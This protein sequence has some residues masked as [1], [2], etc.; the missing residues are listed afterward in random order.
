MA[1]TL[2]RFEAKSRAAWRAWLKANHRTAPGVWLVTH[3]KG[4]GGPHLPWSEVVDEALCFG[5]IDSLP[6][7]LDATRSMIRVTPRKPTSGWSKINRDKVERLI[8][9]DLMTAS[10]LA[11]V[12]L[13]KQ[14]G[15]WKKLEA[16]DSLALPDDLRA[17]LEALPPALKNFEAFPPSARRAILEWIHAAKRPETRLARVA[18]TATQAALNERANQWRPKG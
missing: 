5:W 4:S 8:A 18:Q 2:P 12:A 15:A 9:Q 14:N 13:A 3:K 6:R 11:A 7:K 1:D 10:G 17:K 16:S